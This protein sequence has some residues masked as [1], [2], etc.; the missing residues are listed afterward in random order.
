VEAEKVTLMN[1]RP[2]QW[3]RMQSAA[4]WDKADL[5]SLRQITKGEIIMQHPT[6]DTDWEM[7]NAFGTTETMTILSSFRHGDLEDQNPRNFG[8]VLPG[9]ILKIIDPHSG[10]IVPLGERGEVCIK[11]P[12]LMKGYIGKAPEEVF[13]EDGYYHTG[14]GGHVDERGH[15]FW[16]GRLNDIIKTGGANVSPEEVDTVIARIPGVKRTQ[17]VGV[18]H[19]TLSEMVVSCIVPLEGENLDEG[20]IIAQLK[21]QLASF[22]VPRRV[23][24]F[25]E[26]EFA[27]TG[28]EKVKA[29]ELREKAVQRL[30]AE[31][32]GS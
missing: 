18:P 24:L 26:E 3:A 17:T 28:N 6:V 25:R 4:N 7:P 22:K 13:D 30:A 20:T 14:D 12:T 23:L 15:L 16:E 29:S 8:P 5:S 10:E 32:R 11:G 2:H 9:N 1:G 19:D 31:E 27:L 21:E